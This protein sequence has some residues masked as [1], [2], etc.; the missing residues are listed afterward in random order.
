MY[1]EWDEEGEKREEET[2]KDGVLHGI[3]KRWLT[4]HHYWEYHYNNGEVV[5]QLQYED[6]KLFIKTEYNNNGGNENKKT[7]FYDNGQKHYEENM[8]NYGCDRLSI[9]YYNNGQK[10]CEGNMSNYYRVG[11]WTFYNE[12][13]SVKEVKDY[14]K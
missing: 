6:G 9:W 8:K 10:K 3:R 12:D 11:T 4:S 13:G 14:L 5:K 2:Y 7:T 1:E